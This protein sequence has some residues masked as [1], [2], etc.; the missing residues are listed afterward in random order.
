V[1]D[2][3]FPRPD[4]PALDGAAL[5]AALAGSA[6]WR[7]VEVVEEI[8]STNAE[9]V[10]RAAADEPEGLVLVAEH[11]QAG[12]GRLDRSWTSPPRAGLTVSVL[13][14]PDVPAARRGWLSLLTGVALA[15]T[16]SQVAGVRAS[17]KWPNDLLAPDGAKLAGILAESAG[18]AV[19]IGA[20]LNVSTR[21]EELPDAGSSL[22]LV[23]GAPVD[24]AAVLL[25]LLDSFER[26]YRQWTAALGD[27][28]SSGLAQ[29]YLAWCSTVGATVTV[30]MPDGSVLDGVAEAV[31]WDGRLVVR[32]DAGLLELSSGDVR[33]VRPRRRDA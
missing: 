19:V 14:R 25:G 18:S 17:L 8:G 29:D 32:T 13:V 10:A 9:L 20:G 11:Q 23:A 22:A 26:R 6:L 24:R 15:E 4:R 33:H 31:D 27:P 2:S 12:R 28:V 30:T 16:V 5:T 1:T 3:D 7:A 21:R